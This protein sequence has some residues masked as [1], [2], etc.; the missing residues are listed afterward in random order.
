MNDKALDK[1][2]LGLIAFGMLLGGVAWYMDSESLDK[3]LMPPVAICIGA[4]VLLMAR[5]GLRTGRI[6]SRSGH[7]HRD[8]H[9]VLFWLMVVIC[10]LG[11]SSLVVAALAKLLG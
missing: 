9:P 4:G 8:E 1:L 7:V 2:S 11:G 6:R 10:L 3:A 5:L